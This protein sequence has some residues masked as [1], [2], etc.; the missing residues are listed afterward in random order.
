[1]YL[2]S[3]ILV[4]DQ[5]DAERNYLDELA[6]ALQIAPQLQV[7]LEAQATGQA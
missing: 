3:V 6:A 7:H 1:M 2:V 5:Q 4:D